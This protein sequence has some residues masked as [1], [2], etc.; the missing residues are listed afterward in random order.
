MSL[1]GRLQLLTTFA[2]LV[3][4]LYIYAALPSSALAGEPPDVSYSSVNA[5]PNFEPIEGAS[6]RLVRTD[7]S[8]QMQ[9]TTYGL[10]PGAAYT[11]WWIIFNK[12]WMCSDG[13]CGEEDISPMSPAEVSIL[14][15]TGHLV[16]SNGLGNFTAT[17]KEGQPK[18]E[19]VFGPGLKVGNARTAEVHFVL[20][21]HGP[22]NWSLVHEQISTFNGGCGPAPELYPD[23]EN[24][25]GTVHV[26]Q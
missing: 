17:P 15:A 12:P 1:S 23:C 8:I 2:L 18:G 3:G 16:G 11:G 6:S 13:E 4:V 25:Q 19:V 10:D 21:T 5:F 9:V 24:Q 20:R 14:W 26:P 7:H 22:P